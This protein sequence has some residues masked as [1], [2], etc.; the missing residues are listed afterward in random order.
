MQGKTF[1][2]HQRLL[3]ILDACKA[4]HNHLGGLKRENFL[5]DHKTRDALI[6]QLIIIGEAVIHI[7]NDLL[8]KYEYPWF[9]VR[10]FR[11]YAIHEYFNIEM[12]TLWDVVDIHIPEL[13]KVVKEIIVNEF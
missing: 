3:H 10:A 8:S 6:Y 2:N 11:N 9:K 13:E 1:K 12:W 4:I 7:D 5:N